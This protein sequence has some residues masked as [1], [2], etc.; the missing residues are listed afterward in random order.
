MRS[1]AIMLVLALMHLTLV[2]ASWAQEATGQPQPVVTEDPSQSSASGAGLQAASW[3]LT[4]PYGAV[5]IAFAIGG[6][7]VGGFAW[8]FS[9][10]N[11]DAARAVWVTSVYGTYV[12]TPDHL[13]GD[14][15]VRFLG[16]SGPNGVA[17]ETRSA[18]PVSS[19]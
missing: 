12:I 8:L 6:G 1:V 13:N 15:A 3:L 11:D 19:R 4:I 2:P 7:I 17:V 18:E 14:K 10:G 16:V 9:G 5:K